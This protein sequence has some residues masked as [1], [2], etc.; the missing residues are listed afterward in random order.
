MIRKRM[1]AQRSQGTKPELCLR[2][3]LHRRGLRFRLHRQVIAGT[4]R[5]VD[6]VFGPARVAV[7]VDGCFWHG[8][9]EHG[10]HKP[11]VNQWYWPG[12]IATNRARDADSDRRLKEAGWKVM[13]I[14]EHEDS[15]QAA[16]RVQRV[17]VGRRRKALEVRAD[18]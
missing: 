11:S 18:E 1:Q 16:L 8:C 17:V 12:K 4:R 6:I 3:E 5:Q 15:E 14:W 13:R 2:R 10:S 9:P 7:F